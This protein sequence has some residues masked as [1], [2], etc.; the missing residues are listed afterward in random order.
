MMPDPV[1]QVV[2]ANAKAVRR[3]ALSIWTVYN[4]P[5]DHPHG[6]MARRHEVAKG[7]H[8]STMDTLKA[9]LPEIRKVFRKAGLTRMIRSPED[10]P[11]IVEVW[12]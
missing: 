4:K 11:H 1:R 2:E 9:D 12:L 6:F 3:G 5:K 7:R 10:E 8:R